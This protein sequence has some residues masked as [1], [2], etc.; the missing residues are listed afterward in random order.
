Q[1]ISQWND[2]SS[3]VEQA[4]SSSTAQPTNYR[5]QQ[6]APS[7]WNAQ[8]HQSG[9]HGS[10]DWFRDGVVDTSDWGLQ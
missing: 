4:T 5:T 2:A 6:S 9:H 3:A 7:N 10:D 8:P 1:S